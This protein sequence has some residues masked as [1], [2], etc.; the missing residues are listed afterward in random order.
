MTTIETLPDEDMMA[1]TGGGG[2]PSEQFSGLPMRDLIGGPLQAAAEAAQALRK[3]TQ[4]FL[5]NV[6][7]SDVNLGTGQSAE[8]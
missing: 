2:N 6:G 3:S 5:S 1:V 7:L 8:K 4:D